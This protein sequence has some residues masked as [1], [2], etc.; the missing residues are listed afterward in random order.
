MRCTQYGT[1]HFR[2]NRT[3]LCSLHALC[4]RLSR[5]HAAHMTAT[6][7]PSHR[8]PETLLV[9]P[10]FDEATGTASYLVMAPK[11]REC[12]LVDTVGGYTTGSGTISHTVADALIAHIR[13][14]DGKLMWILE[15]YVHVDQLTAPLSSRTGSVA[16]PAPAHESPKYSRRSPGCSIF[17]RT[18]RPMAH[19]LIGSLQTAKRFALAP[20][21]W[22]PY[23]R[24]A[25][26]RPA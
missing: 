23:T 10:R 12:T 4:S 9:E 3:D 5:D 13:A 17:H 16:A 21:P 19:N 1:A 11:S 15:T 20:S 14:L 25:A 2:H 18:F 22:P 24:Q 8:S 6:I 7:Y 26:R